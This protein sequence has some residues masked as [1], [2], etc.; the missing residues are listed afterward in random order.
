MCST[1]LPANNPK[2]TPTET[3][4]RIIPKAYR[5]ASLPAHDVVYMPIHMADSD[6][7]QHVPQGARY[8]TR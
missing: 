2:A 7:Q 4:D 8:P 3:S 5:L 6:R 1:K